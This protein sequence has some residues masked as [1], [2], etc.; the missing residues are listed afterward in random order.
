[1]SSYVF[2]KLFLNFNYSYTRINN[3]CSCFFTFIFIVLPKCKWWKKLDLWV[4]LCSIWRCQKQIWSKIL[5][6]FN[7]IYCFRFRSSVFTSLCCCFVQIS[8]FWYKRIINFFI[9]CCFRVC[10]WVK[11]WCDGVVNKWFVIFKKFMLK[12]NFK[13]RNN[14][15][16]A[17]N[18]AV[19]RPL[20]SFLTSSHLHSFITNEFNG[21]LVVLSNYF[22]ASRLE[23]Y[24]PAVF[25]TI[26]F[27]KNTVT[28]SLNKN[29]LLPLLMKFFKY[30]WFLKCSLLIDMWATDFIARSERFEVTYVLISPFLRKR[31]YLRAY[32]SELEPIP[33]VISLF[34]AANWLERE[35]WDLYGVLFLNHPDLR[36]ILTDYGFLGHPLRKN[37][38]LT[39]FSELRYDDVSR[40]VVSD[41]LEL[42][43]EMRLFFFLNPWR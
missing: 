43:Q 10:L 38:P 40:K 25:R 16:T 28:F 18:V 27:S 42:V 21:K 7:F 26:H 8:C 22:T 6:S 13:F 36:R 2:N 39:G 3:F 20:V 35:I 9:F 24:L 29:T 30:S 33:S 37:F 34:S 32:T 19:S 31:L 41:S 12:L 15:T 17:R 23:Q 11:N 4:W 1:M 14:C 5:F